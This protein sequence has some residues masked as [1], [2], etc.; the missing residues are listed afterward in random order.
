MNYCSYFEI[1]AKEI[2]NRKETIGFGDYR[3]FAV[4]AFYGISMK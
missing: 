1:K 3:L 4:D 2:E